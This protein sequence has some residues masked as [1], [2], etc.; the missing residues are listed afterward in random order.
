MRALV[1]ED[2]R[3][4]RRL[5]ADV[6]GKRG[7]DVS[8]VGSAEEAL[9]LH[10]EHPF[11]L[12]LV[13]W[14]LPGMDGLELCRR[15]R[16]QADGDEPVFI[17]LTSRDKQEHVL[18]AL[19]AGVND[20]ITKPVDH[21]VLDTRLTIAER[22]V[23]E[24]RRRKQAE[25]ALQSS[26][27]SFRLLIEALPDAV[28]VHRNGRIVYVNPAA[29]HT[30]G[31]ERA[32][33]IIGRPYPELL[34]PQDRGQVIKRISRM[35]ASGEAA[36]PHEE[37]FLG[38]NGRI[39]TVEVASLPM[40]FKGQPAALAIAR[41]LTERKRM[42]SQLLL[43][44][45]MVS[46]GTLAA[47]I[48]HEIN[49]PLAYVISNLHLLSERMES[50]RDRLDEATGNDIHE[51]L[52]QAQDGAERVRTI[53]RDLKSFSRADDE[54]L[55]AVDVER[56]LDSAVSMA[57]NEIRHRARL[58]KSYAQ[59]PAVHA[60]EA[61][62]GQVFL[63]LLVNAA[64][65]LPVSNAQEHEIRVATSYR[66]TP[67][68]QVVIEVSDTGVGMP[69][70]VAKRIFDPFF[71]T[72]PVGVGT[73]LGLSICH[74]IVDTMGGHIQVDSQPERGTTMRVHLPASSVPARRSLR[75]APRCSG[76]T[77]RTRILIVD[78]EP[79]VARSLQRALR[80]H[81]V[82]VALSGR[83]AVEQLT[84]DAGYDVVFCDLMMPDM[85]GMELY[86]LASQVRPGLEERMIFMTGGAFTSRAQAFLESIPN[87]W[88]EKPFDIRLVQ[89]LV[90]GSI[91]EEPEDE[92]E[93]VSNG[94]RG[95]SMAT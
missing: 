43:A 81:D 11:A 94:A 8:E 50:L 6:V 87:Q 4:T 72:K 15:T 7:H 9:G 14:V 35:L 21:S 29:L 31:Y 22:T 36:P 65:A 48:A 68:D 73:G 77:Q 46:V 39:A 71:T 19:D 59:V 12:M 18:S 70:D 86:E 91:D 23:Q 63:N 74:S 67:N 85:S 2:D 82:S 79:G 93:G 54:R 34:H 83:D 95:D 75:P 38:A 28:L 52:A 42:E 17:L 69:P 40:E 55:G 88:F 56:V 47:G 62:L 25:A 3:L 49:N 84:H 5:I 92:E 89:D 45:R 30:L 16:E 51:M 64:Q 44:D 41:D 61:K 78:D 90:H 1:C 58:V 20:Y 13:D 26:E 53:V 66:G 76:H 32:D 33:Q 24:R 27:E 80:G 60:N 37:R 10:T 57:W